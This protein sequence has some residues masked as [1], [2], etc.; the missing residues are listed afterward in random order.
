MTRRFSFLTALVILLGLAGGVS[1]IQATR[2]IA[3]SI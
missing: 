2:P 1:T 3:W